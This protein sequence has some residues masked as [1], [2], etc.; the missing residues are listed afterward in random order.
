MWFTVCIY[1]HY[2]DCL[3]FAQGQ[4]TASSNPFGSLNFGFGTPPVISSTPPVL[5]AAD[6]NSTVEV[7]N[8]SNSDGD[9]RGST[10]DVQ[11]QPVVSANNEVE[12][13]SNSN[14]PVS[15]E[16]EKNIEGATSTTSTNRA[17]VNNTT[18]GGHNHQDDTLSE[19]QPE[20]VEQM[21]DFNLQLNEDSEDT[22]QIDSSTLDGDD[23]A[24]STTNASNVLPEDSNSAEAIAPYEDLEEE[25]D[26]DPTIPQ[27]VTDNKT[28]FIDS[29]VEDE[30]KWFDWMATIIG[31]DRE[32]G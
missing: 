18:N 23:S 11:K 5:A 25:D 21:S 20:P 7:A 31:W 15:D 28:S 27:E 26:H 24:N 10:E 12:S 2:I 17:E 16:I 30:V 14:R 8:D 9:A 19:A 1:I 13:S 4:G 32:V 3:I 22:N 29:T 6:S